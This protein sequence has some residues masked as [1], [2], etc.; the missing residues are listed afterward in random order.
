MTKAVRAYLRDCYDHS[1]Q[2]N[3]LSQFY[4]DTATSLLNTFLAY[5]GHKTNEIIKLLTLVSS[6][7]IPLNFI[8]S[9]YGM[10]FD[11]AHSPLNM[12]EL[13]WYYGYPFA[14]SL[15]LVVA[16]GMISLFRRRGWIDKSN[17]ARRRR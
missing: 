3:E 1:A 9:I 7:F 11:P 8:A 6:V 14:L 12:P 5:E 15:M 13:D 4:R 2:A 16:L 17:Q 10:N